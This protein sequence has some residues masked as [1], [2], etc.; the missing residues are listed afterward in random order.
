MLEG[1]DLELAIRL[2]EPVSQ[3]HRAGVIP[4]T[5]S[6]EADARA[7]LADSDGAQER[8]ISHGPSA[9]AP[10]VLVGQAERVAVR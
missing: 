2:T 7:L 9:G 8:P 10:P 5:L 3:A 1:M 4:G 6:V